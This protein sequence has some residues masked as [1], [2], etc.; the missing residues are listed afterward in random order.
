MT[1]ASE[2]TYNSVIA[3]IIRRYPD[4]RVLTYHRVKRL[5]THLTGIVPII[6]DMCINSCVGYTGPFAALTCCRVVE[7]DMSHM[8]LHSQKIPHES[9]FTP[10]QLHLSCRHYGAPK[11]CRQHRLTALFSL[12]KFLAGIQ[13][14]QDTKITLCGFFNGT[15]YL[16]AVQE[17]KINPGDMVLMLSIDGAQLYRN[18]V[19]ECW[20]W[21]YIVFD[22]APDDR[23]KKK[24]HSPRWI[25]PRGKQTQKY[26]Q[27]PLKRTR[28]S[29]CYAK[30]GLTG[31]GC[32]TE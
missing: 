32:K 7:Q 2:A 10:F 8:T 24:T 11:G 25:Y 15:D 18:K 29:G 13:E 12:K 3:G 30:E 26:R 19:S 16:N 9:S 4:S 31:L 1:N 5:I 14:N 21:I 23:Y 6:R 28:Q 22:H 17:G 20:I 27:L